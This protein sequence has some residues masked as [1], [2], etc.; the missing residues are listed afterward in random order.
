MTKNLSKYKCQKCNFYYS[1]WAG[2]CNA[3]GAWGTIEIDEAFTKGQIKKVFSGKVGKVIPLQTLNNAEIEPERVKIGITEFDRVIGGGLVEASAILLSGDPGIG[4][5][6]LLLQVA[7]ETANRHK[8]VIYI[9]GEESHAQIT[10]RARRLNRENSSLKIACETN[11]RDIL[12]TLHEE[13]VDLLIVDSIQTIYTDHIDSAPGSVSQ[14]RTCVL[15]LT[16]YAKKKG[17]SIIF[18]GHV[19]KDGQIAGPKLVEHMVDTVL[20]FEGE[21]GMHF[22]ILRAVKNRFGA[23]DEI[24]VFE[25]T[26]R[27]LREVYNPSELFL[28]ERNA[29]N[30]GSVVFSAIEGTRPLLVEIQAL[31]APS[32]IATPRRN[33][34]GL[35]TARLAMVIA[36]LDARCGVSFTGKDVYL[37]V[38]GGMRILEP[39]ADL[40]VAVAL[41][42]ASQDILIPPNTAVFG[43]LG[44]SGALRQVT[45]ADARISEA[46]KLGFKSIFLPKASKTRDHNDLEL[47][48]YE[49]ILELVSD[50]LIKPK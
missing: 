9:S 6:T 37:N 40:A 16:G 14:V 45:Q 11:L 7:T 19:T 42:F 8:N 31:V 49:S 44:L 48:E 41:L 12:T 25:M 28:S 5:S 17:V 46:K 34:V 38:A 18:V 24:G 43:E 10:M 4:K 32:S 3:C 33:A 47:K 26:N 2:K 1:K 13:K 23:S 22:R 15:D 50:N 21:R 30:N 20:H 27:G 39:A 35:D 36:I 29:A